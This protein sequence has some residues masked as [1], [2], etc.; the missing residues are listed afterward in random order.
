MRSMGYMAQWMPLTPR[1]GEPVYG[2]RESALKRAKRYRKLR[3]KEMFKIEPNWDKSKFA[4]AKREW[5]P[6]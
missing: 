6:K 2:S 3:P 4:V 5:S 1:S